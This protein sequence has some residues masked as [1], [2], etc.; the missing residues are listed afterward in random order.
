MVNAVMAGGVDHPF[1]WSQMINKLGVNPKLPQQ[2]KLSVCSTVT[3]R[4]EESHRQIEHLTHKRQP[5][6]YYATRNINN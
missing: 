3:G 6:T 5:T 2:I 1:E 4:D